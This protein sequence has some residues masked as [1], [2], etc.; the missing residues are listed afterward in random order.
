MRVILTLEFIGWFVFF[1]LKHNK[2]E[3]K[4]FQDCCFSYSHCSRAVV[5]KIVMFVY[6]QPVIKVVVEESE[7]LRPSFPKHFSL[8]SVENILRSRK[9]VTKNS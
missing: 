9:D 2:T 8:T 1:N 4:T 5:P 6:L 3:A 7:K